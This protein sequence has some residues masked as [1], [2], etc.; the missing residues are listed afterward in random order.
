VCQSR[1]TGQ[2]SRRVVEKNKNNNKNKKER[3]HI[4]RIW[5][6]APSRPICN[7]FVFRVRLMGVIYCAKFYRN[8]LEGLDFVGGRIL[9]IPIGLR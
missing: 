6:D 8:R 9:T 3:P 7:K 5:P 2:F 4:S 1:P